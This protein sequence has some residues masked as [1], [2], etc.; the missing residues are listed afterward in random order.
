M[1]NIFL[2]ISHQTHDAAATSIESLPTRKRKWKMEFDLEKKYA[3]CKELMSK[4]TIDLNVLSLLMKN[5]VMSNLN[6][7]LVVTI[8]RSRIRKGDSHIYK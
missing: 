5:R 3:I 2:N 7:T 8:H 1:I 6:R 4:M